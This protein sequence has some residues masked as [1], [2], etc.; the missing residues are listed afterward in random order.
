ML[1]VLPKWNA[2]RWILVAAAAA[3]VAGASAG[4]LTASLWM[5]AVEHSLGGWNAD[6]R[7]AHAPGG[8][9]DCQGHAG[10]AHAESERAGEDSVTLSPQARKNIG[11][12][13]ATVRLEDFRRTVKIPAAVVAR[14]GRSEITVSAPMTG[15]VT[16]IHP[17]RGEAVLPGDP[18]FDLRLT[19][20]DLV[21]KQ[22]E[23]L[24]DLEQLDVIQEE[25]ARLEQ[26]TRSGSVAGKALLERVYEQRKVEASVRAT[27]EALLLHGLNES[28]IDAIE[29]ER[30]LV[31]ELTVE[32]PPLDEGHAG[33]D[34]EDI[35]Q[36]AELAVRR[37]DH[38]QTGVPLAVL[39]D[40]CV[41]YVEG[42]AFEQDAEALHRAADEAAPVTALV[43]RPGAAKEAVTDLRI[44]YVENQVDRESRA[45]RF[46]VPLPNHL[47][48]NE[49]TPDG[50]RF[51]AWRYKPGQRVEVLLP[52]ETWTGKLVLP[53]ESVVQEGAE[54]FVYL[55]SGNRFARRPV[56]ELYRD[57]GHSVIAADGALFPG[58]V[59]AAKGAYQIHLDLKNRSGGAIDPHAGHSH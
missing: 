12:T 23:L 51:I 22:S 27:R 53:V 36:V 43:E 13:L 20:E 19:H 56:H 55:A 4:L 45:L 5:P 49:E 52:V 38:V 47:V 40:Q 59:V 25:V 35:L 39:S 24:R 10:H 34:H 58:D 42:R 16:R 8:E 46:Y 50:H 32:A 31:R 21:E 30:R 1:R 2:R 28:Q 6:R 41:L 11:L 7:A 48:R 15:I 14:P 57:Q 3:L 33:A 29:R 18:L 17:L 44:L 54:R 9:P 26:V 37:G